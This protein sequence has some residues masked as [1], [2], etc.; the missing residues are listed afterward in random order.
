MQALILHASVH[1]LSF[2]EIDMWTDPIVA[3]IHKVREA[4]AASHDNDLKKI[5]AYFMAQQKVKAVS[6]VKRPVLPTPDELARASGSTKQ[7]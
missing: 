5:A 4:I 1:L 7:A 2:G 3:D 6:V